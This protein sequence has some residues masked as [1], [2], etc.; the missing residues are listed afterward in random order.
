MTYQYHVTKAFRN[1]ENQ[2]IAEVWIKD[3][4]LQKIDHSQWLVKEETKQETVY[5]LDT[6]QFHPVSL[7]CVSPNYWQGE[8]VGN[9]HYFFMLKGAKAPEK[10]RSI[11]NEFLI[12]ELYNY[13]KVLEVLGNQL[14]VDSTP[15]QLSGLGFNATVRDEV[16]LRLTGD[17]ENNKQKLIKVTF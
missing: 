12:P 15:N 4:H 1:K 6:C 13:R 10:I 16:V 5:G 14:K 11:Y 17:F 2:T 7:V 8:G 3:G 9:K